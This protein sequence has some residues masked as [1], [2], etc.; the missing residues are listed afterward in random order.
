[1]LARIVIFALATASMSALAADKVYFNAAVYTVDPNQPWVSAFAVENG[2]FVAV[3]TDSK[4]K[5]LATEATR[6]V[7][8]KG[9]FVMPG[10]ID[11]HTHPVRV[12]MMEDV[13]FRNDNFTPRTPAEFGEILKAYA[14][15]NPN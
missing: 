5:A 1:M 7:D 11:S 3:G 13:L 8:M 15:A 9:Q 6:L 12:I 10:M 4:V 2:E 14:D